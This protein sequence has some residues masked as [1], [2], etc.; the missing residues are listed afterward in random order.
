[1]NKVT[2]NS[3]EIENVKRIKAVRLQ[4][5]QAGLTVIGG[6]NNQGKS[7][8]L[9]AI[10]Y[11][12]GGGE[13]KPANVKRE[14]SMVDPHMKITLS[15]G[16]TVERKGKNSE[17]KVSDP[18]G[19]K[20]GQT[21][22][23]EFVSTFALNL[24]KFMNASNK[25]KANALL[26]TLGIGDKLAK[27]DLEEQKLYQERLAIGRIRDE[28]VGHYEQMPQW[29]GVPEEEVSMAE[30]LKQQ[31]EIL[32][33]NG[34]R[35]QWKRDYDL[36]MDETDRLEREIAETESRLR[37]LRG[38]HERALEKLHAA[39]KTPAEMQMESTEELEARLAHIDEI[40]MKVRAN[41]AKEAASIDADSYRE[42]YQELSRQIELLRMDRQSLLDGAGLPLPELS[43]EKGELIYKGQP[44]GNMSG[45]E[46]LKVATAIVRKIKPACGFV[47]IDKLEQM[48]QDT[49]VDFAAWL[50]DEGLQAIATRVSTGD[51]CTIYIEDGY[52]VDKHGNRTADTDLKE[53]ALM[54]KAEEQAVPAPKKWKVGEF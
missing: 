28:K 52:S 9:D 20:A 4:P 19:R 23:N 48:D 5:T 35:M 39:E 49:L 15:N 50:Q 34:Q 17:L 36:L 22:L 33:R 16:I 37:I 54:K 3:L 24:P 14:G 32:G 47:L 18:S 38:D 51:E 7:S 41:K 21:L 13:F 12:L 31:Q 10:A 40:N 6:K 43:F 11:A 1:M 42:K 8:V 53:A 46:Q 2:I 26:Q 29:D 44:W 27:F 25:E 45:S 30:L